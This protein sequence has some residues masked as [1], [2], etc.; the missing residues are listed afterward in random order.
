MGM[1]ALGTVTVAL[2]TAV[3]SEYVAMPLVV[4]LAPFAVATLLS[5]RL[6]KPRG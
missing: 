1:G 3:G 4:G 2:L 5:A 6:L